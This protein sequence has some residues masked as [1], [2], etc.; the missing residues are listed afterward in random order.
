M[1]RLQGLAAQKIYMQQ[2]ESAIKTPI[3]RR[4][5]LVYNRSID[6]SH[7][8][9]LFPTIAARGTTLR[10]VVSAASA[11]KIVAVKALETAQV[12]G[13]DMGLERQM[14]YRGDVPRT[15]IIRAS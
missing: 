12:A 14:R 5:S 15:A 2:R 4:S 10:A 11:L 13:V 9:E 8:Q 7:L 6:L 1:C 3:V